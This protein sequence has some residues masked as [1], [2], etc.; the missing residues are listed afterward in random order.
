MPVS[1]GPLLCPSPPDQKSRVAVRAFGYWYEGGALPVANVSRVPH[2]PSVTERGAVR[3]KG[4]GVRTK[5]C[6]RYGFS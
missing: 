4:F 2:A 1:W 3:R 6:L 5:T